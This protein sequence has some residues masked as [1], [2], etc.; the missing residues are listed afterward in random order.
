MAKL[1]Q[2]LDDTAENPRFIETVARRA[3][4]FI[5]PVETYA[6]WHPAHSKKKL[7]SQRVPGAGHPWGVA[8]DKV[9]FGL[10][11]LAGKIWS[12]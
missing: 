6:S 5:A 8:Q 1:R 7:G 10:V 3:Y 11:E 2:A 12:V 9:V 4:L